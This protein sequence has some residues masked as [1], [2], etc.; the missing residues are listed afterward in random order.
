MAALDCTAEI[1]HDA[2]DRSVGYR[3]ER[4]IECVWIEGVPVELDMATR[5]R[6]LTALDRRLAMEDAA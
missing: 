4:L 5:E 3:G 1:F 2:P 6:I